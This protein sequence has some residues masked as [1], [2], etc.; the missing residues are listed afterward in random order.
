MDFLVNICG[1]PRFSYSYALAILL[2]S[3]LVKLALTP[4]SNKQ[5]A[6]MKEMQK[7]QPYIKE[8]Q[9]KYKNDK[10][11]QGRKMHGTVQGARR[12][13]GRRLPA[14]CWSNSRSCTCCIT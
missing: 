12:Q 11:A 4:L 6:S 1:G 7:L 2:I 9:A 10:E 5:Y 3:V 8:I 13:P 14:A